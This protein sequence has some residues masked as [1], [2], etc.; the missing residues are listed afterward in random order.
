MI[1][2]K[3]EQSEATKDEAAKLP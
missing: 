2:K 3:R 1:K